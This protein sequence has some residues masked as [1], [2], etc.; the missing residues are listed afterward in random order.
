MS[1]GDALKKLEDAVAKLD[2]A[3]V[4]LEDAQSALTSDPCTRKAYLDVKRSGRAARRMMQSAPHMVFADALKE[5]NDAGNKLEDLIA[6]LEDVESTLADGAA[7]QKAIRNAKSAG[8]GAAAIVEDVRRVL[9]DIE[10]QDNE[11]RARFSSHS[12]SVVY[13]DYDY[14]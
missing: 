14:D 9:L 2:N 8:L 4:I 5:V 10:R 6:A 3:V 13:D 1:F 7:V 11:I 12:S